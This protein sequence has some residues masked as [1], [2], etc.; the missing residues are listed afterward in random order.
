SRARTRE[1]RR[2]SNGSDTASC[3]TA[4]SG[5][6]SIRR[7]ILCSEKQLLLNHDGHDG[8][9]ELQMVLAPSYPLCP[10]AASSPRRVVWSLSVVPVVPVVVQLL[11]P[12]F[13]TRNSAGPGAATWRARR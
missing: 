7:S 3:A 11:L 6:N 1:R 12:L 10:L 2:S 8:H 9:K 4:P 13:K 5:A